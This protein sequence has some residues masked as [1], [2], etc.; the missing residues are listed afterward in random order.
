[1][2][3]NAGQLQ[4]ILDGIDGTRGKRFKRFTPH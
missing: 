2:E 4:M 3:L 1:M